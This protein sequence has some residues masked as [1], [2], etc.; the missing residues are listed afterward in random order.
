MAAFRFSR[1]DRSYAALKY[2]STR[3][4]GVI[5]MA[6]FK[7][8][9]P[10]AWRRR[11]ANPFPGSRWRHPRREC[12]IKN[13]NRAGVGFVSQRT[14]AALRKGSDDFSQVD[15]TEVSIGRR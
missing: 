14:P 4:V 2:G 15:S 6:V 1:V 5:G 10:G 7:E 3:N 11:G 9:E 13:P 12:K 8:N